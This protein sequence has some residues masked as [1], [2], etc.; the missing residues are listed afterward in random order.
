MPQRTVRIGSRV[1]LHARPAALVAQAA[2]ASGLRVRIAAGDGPEVDAASVL[3]LMTL[4]AKHGDEVTLSVE[5]DGADQVL[6]GLASLI[7][8]D[9]DAVEPV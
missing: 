8:S 7:G 9:L 3:R 5:G 2:S 1:G 4:G 6:D